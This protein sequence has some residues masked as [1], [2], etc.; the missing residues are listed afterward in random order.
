M[1]LKGGEESFEAMKKG[2]KFGCGCL[3]VVRGM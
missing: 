2:G 3:D 1:S